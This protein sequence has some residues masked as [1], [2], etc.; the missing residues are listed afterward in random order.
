M[1]N[2]CASQS[3]PMLYVHVISSRLVSMYFGYAF[4]AN[5]FSFRLLNVPRILLH[6]PSN[7]FYF[8]ANDQGKLQL[9]PFYSVGIK[10]TV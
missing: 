2:E 1:T 3:F 9:F 5:D 4:K 6:Q 7:T 8:V 10:S